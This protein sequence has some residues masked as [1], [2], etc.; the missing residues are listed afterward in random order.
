MTQFRIPCKNQFSPC[1][2]NLYY[3]RQSLTVLVS[4]KPDTKTGSQQYFT[5]SLIKVYS[6][7][8][9][10]TFDTQYIY[11]SFLSETFKKIEVSVDFEKNLA[12]GKAI[13]PM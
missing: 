1:L 3:D 2:V 12:K 4:F 5:P 8:R 13:V 10:P 6:P 11:V 7:S 9:D